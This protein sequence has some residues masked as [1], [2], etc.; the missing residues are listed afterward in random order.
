MSQSYIV[1][2]AAGQGKRMHSDLPKVLHP[3]GERCLLEHVVDAAAA[4]QPESVLVVYGHG[5]ELVRERLPELQVEWVRQEQQLGTG[6]AVAQAMQFI[7]DDA[8][9]VVLNGDV[10][11]IQTETIIALVERLQSS[12]CMVVVTVVPDDPSGYGRIVR[13]SN[14]AVTGI[15]EQR[16]ASEGQL[17]IGEINTGIMGL[18]AAKLRGWLS[19]LKSD[20]A[21]GEYYLTDV[22][23]F[24]VRDEVKV[25]TVTAPAADDLLGVNDRVQL[26]FLERR[27]QQSRVDALMMVGATV[28]DPARL[29]IRGVV[30]CGRDVHLDV[31]VLLEGNVHL[32][33]GARVGANTVLRNVRVGANT[34]IL[35]N[36]VVEDVTIGEHCRIGPFTR[37]RPGTVLSNAVQVGNFVEVKK[38]TIATG[39]KVNHLSYV[40]DSDVGEDVNIGAGTIT[41]NYDGANKHRTVIGDR[42]FIGSGT[43]L[44]A[45]VVIA[46]GTT[47]GAGSTITCDTESDSLAVSRARQRAIAGW[48][49][50]QK[51]TKTRK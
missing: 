33:D 31:N 40:G 46:P 8:H 42:T 44:V 7:P 11:L 27:Y 32:G 30:H 37:L 29:D 25:E 21:Q 36:C 19:E 13:D 39:S 9:V 35:E 12:D 23:G 5:G 18:P 24:A 1:I 28:R 6:H 17:A 34:V 48:K 43:E 16:D 20:N 41:C 45:P 22:I 50:P 3:V 14:G 47:V 2:L 10:P 15:V 49:R 38:S 26:A 4:S 51:Q